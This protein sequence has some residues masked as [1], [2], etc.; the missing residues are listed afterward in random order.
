MKTRNT[1][2]NKEKEKPIKG[3]RI[4]P[5]KG[6]N[7]YEADY[8]V[9]SWTHALLAVF[10]WLEWPPECADMDC[11]N[12]IVDIDN[13]GID[14]QFTGSGGANGNSGGR[15]RSSSSIA[16]PTTST[17]SAT[18]G[19]ITSS[20]PLSARLALATTGYAAHE[21]VKEAPALHAGK[22]VGEKIRR[23]SKLSE[24]VVNKRVYDLVLKSIAEGNGS[25]PWGHSWLRV[26]KSASG[27]NERNKS[28]AKNN[29]GNQSCGRNNNL[30]G[31]KATGGDKVDD[32]D[33]YLSIRP[34]ELQFI[35]QEC[36]SSLAK[37][38]PAGAAAKNGNLPHARTSGV[39]GAG[40]G[41]FGAAEVVSAATHFVWVFPSTCFRL[42][43]Q[44]GAQRGVFKLKFPPARLPKPV[45]SGPAVESA[46]A[47]DSAPTVDPAM[48][49]ASAEAVSSVDSKS[50]S[51]PKASVDLKSGV[52]SP[53]S[54]ADSAVPTKSSL[55]STRKNHAR[56]LTKSTTTTGERSGLL[57]G[58]A[59][60]EAAKS[61][62]L[63]ATMR[64]VHFTHRRQDY[65]GQ[66][67]SFSIRGAS[68]DVFAGTRIAVFDRTL[69]QLLRGELQPVNARGEEIQNLRNLP[70]TEKSEDVSEELYKY[71]GTPGI[72]HHPDLRIGLF[73]PR[74][75]LHELDQHLD[76]TPLE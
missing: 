38:K 16:V 50:L 1:K 31:D 9:K 27:N 63:L 20:L 65:R 18:S 51:D 52:D 49:S 46:P 43:D 28:C 57:S 39:S 19:A 11:G 26:V 55:R 71:A 59:A 2:S 23:K 54:A 3:K 76:K 7:Q 35:W 14:A 67:F 72:W 13:A 53:T 62:R 48:D 36:L 12:D 64:D 17:A 33:S 30:G 24:K 21:D 66:E 25:D 69:T 32:A 45:D 41:A 47:V 22:K 58:V 70:R 15:N 40:S 60:T 5:G 61:G 4:S 8:L 42:A 75:A 37:S 56:L 29:E 10:D 34:E 6:T 68:L 44:L 73:D 74:R